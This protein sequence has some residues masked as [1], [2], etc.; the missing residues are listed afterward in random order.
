[1]LNVG[2]KEHM[3]I[4]VETPSLILAGR[5]ALI[6]DASVNELAYMQRKMQRVET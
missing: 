4:Q 3:R 5:A 2:Q 6:S 1:M